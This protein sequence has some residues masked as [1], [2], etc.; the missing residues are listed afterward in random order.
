ML[1]IVHNF[2]AVA[3]IEKEILKSNLFYSEDA[4]AKMLYKYYRKKN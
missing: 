3:I 1:Y 2:I 4:N